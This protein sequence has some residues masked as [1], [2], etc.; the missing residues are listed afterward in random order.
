M[1]LYVRLPPYFIGGIRYSPWLG[2]RRNLVTCRN[3]KILSVLLALI[4]QSGI[5]LGAGTEPGAPGS[6]GA[7]ADSSAIAV[8]GEV[9]ARVNGAPVT[10]A[11]VDRAILVYLAQSR[12]SHDLTPE[13]RKEAE[14]GALEQ[15]IGAKLLLQNGLKLKID[16]LE[17]QVAAKLAQSKVK[18][19]SAAAYDQALKTNNLTEPEAQEI[20]RNDIVAAHLL[21]KEVV[22]KITVSASEVRDYYQQNLDRFTQP[23]GTQISHILIE[24]AA[25]ATLETKLRALG[26]AEAVRKKLLAG[27]DFAALAKSDSSCPSKE[28]GG[29]LGLFGK[30]EMIPEFAVAVAALKPGEISQ[31]V[32]TS[33]GFHVV[34]LVARKPVTVSTLGEVQGKIESYLKQQRT[35][36]AIADYVSGLKKSAVIVLAAGK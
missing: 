18:F 35:Q 16:H 9:L 19:P 28:E 34:K 3:L 23:E 10:R 2:L 14:N 8:P 1:R 24:V 36:Q 11:E 32:E 30:E 4:F 15:L 20:V 6:A 5:S 27:A 7:P 29:D 21:D 13:A 22:D 25:D 17:S 33:F 12:L 31:V 26:K